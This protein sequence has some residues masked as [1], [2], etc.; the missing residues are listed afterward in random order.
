M[1]KIALFRGNSTNYSIRSNILDLKKT[2]PI[3][4]SYYL[5]S[6]YSRTYCITKE[7]PTLIAFFSS[8]R[9]LVLSRHCIVSSTVVVQLHIILLLFDVRRL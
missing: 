2:R 5:N 1:L 6:P 3:A 7:S 4:K 8:R 9:G